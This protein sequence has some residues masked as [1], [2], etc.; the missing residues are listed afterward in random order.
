M[1]CTLASIWII[2]A[3]SMSVKDR[4]E[5]KHEWMNEFQAGT[6]SYVIIQKFQLALI[7]RNFTQSQ[8]MYNYITDSKR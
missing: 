4:T 8:W 1:L 5:I 3:Y 6:Q 7:Q 2:M